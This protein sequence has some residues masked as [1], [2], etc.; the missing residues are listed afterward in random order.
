MP[1]MF[2]TMWENPRDFIDAYY[3]RN[4]KKLKSAETFKILFAQ[5]R[6]DEGVK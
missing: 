1:G 4:G 2:A 6:K 5:I 3:G